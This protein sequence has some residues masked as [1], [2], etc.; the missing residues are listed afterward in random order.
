MG[1]MYSIITTILDDL[2]S[3]RTT[4]KVARKEYYT[5]KIVGIGIEIKNPTKNWKI[6][7]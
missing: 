7:L 6:I 1:R 2:F 3:V 5:P 4:S